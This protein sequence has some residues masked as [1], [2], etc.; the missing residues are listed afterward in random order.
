MPRA[1]RSTQARSAMSCCSH[2]AA[3]GET[4]DIVRIQGCSVP[5]GGAF[6]Q[7]LETEPTSMIAATLLG[8]RRNAL[9]FALNRM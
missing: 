9:F 4:S 6:K 2:H 8:I 3:L 5:A 7:H 1:K